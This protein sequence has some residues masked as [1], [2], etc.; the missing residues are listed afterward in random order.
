MDACAEVQTQGSLLV[1]ERAS[2]REESAL[3]FPIHVNG[4]L[5]LVIGRQ[6]AVITLERQADVVCPGLIKRS[7]VHE[8]V[9]S[10][11]RY[12]RGSQPVRHAA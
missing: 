1:L 9:V 10:K 3:G 5:V 12:K 2:G 8:G 7:L 4:K 6:V 11:R